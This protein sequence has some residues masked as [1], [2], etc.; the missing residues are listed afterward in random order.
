MRVG[1]NATAGV[2]GAYCSEHTRERSR[3][4]LRKAVDHHR[5]FS[6]SRMNIDEMKSRCFLQKRR[7][8]VV[9]IAA[10]RKFGALANHRKLKMRRE[11][12]RLIVTLQRIDRLEQELVA[13]ML[14]RRHFVLVI[15]DAFLRQNIFIEDK[16]VAYFHQQ[17]AGNGLCA[18]TDNRLAK[19]LELG[20]ER[21]KIGIARKYG[22]GIDMFFG[23]TH[24][25][26]IYSKANV[27]RILAGGRAIGN[28]DELDSQLVQ[29]G[30]IVLKTLP[31]AVGALHGDAAFVHETVD[32][33]AHVGAIVLGR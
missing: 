7:K 9:S 21:R 24:L 29:G 23:Q 20:H 30:D 31:I 28:L 15:G 17:R 10:L 26:R 8:T 12:S 32:H 25:H 1:V 22:K 14:L 6:I 16:F 33:R 19:F 2:S 4:L 3:L 11:N 5:P 13:L 27:G 18:D